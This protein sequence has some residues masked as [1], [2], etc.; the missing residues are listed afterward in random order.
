MYVLSYYYYVI[1]WRVRVHIYT[2]WF[3]ELEL[4]K[5]LYSLQE[6]G[7]ENE[8]NGRRIQATAGDEGIVSR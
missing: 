5:L 8:S 7:T 4:V 6:G 2:N 1:H 3:S